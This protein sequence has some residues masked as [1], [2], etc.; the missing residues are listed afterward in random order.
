[1]GE[2]FDRV[3]ILRGLA[4]FFLKKFYCITNACDKSLLSRGLD[5]VLIID[6][7]TTLGRG[8]HV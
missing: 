5:W 4:M 8:I 3:L 2:S 6:P 1:M 7:E